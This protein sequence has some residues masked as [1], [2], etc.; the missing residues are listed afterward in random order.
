[1]EYYFAFKRTE[2]LT[3]HAITWMILE[4]IRLGEIGQSHKD[5]C[6]MISHIWSTQSGQ[7]HR[8]RAE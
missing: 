6:C 7:V 5:T 3:T 8:N 4:D 2:I 1:M